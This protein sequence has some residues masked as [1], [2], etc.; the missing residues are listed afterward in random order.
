MEKRHNR[1]AVLET[2]LDDHLRPMVRLAEEFAPGRREAEDW[3]EKAFLRACRNMD[4][5]NGAD[6]K[7]LLYGSLVELIEDGDRR[8]AG[9]S[10]VNTPG[11]LSGE[12]A[13]SPRSV[14]RLRMLM[15][16]VDG[17]EV[18]RVVSDLPHEQRLLTLLYYLAG[19]TQRQ[20]AKLTGL[21]LPQVR[22]RLGDSRR[23]LQEFIWRQ[24]SPEDQH[25]TVES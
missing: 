13:G 10:T 8:I 1:K 16:R 5:N 21:T 23:R 18:Y 25:V 15:S 14:R 19:F 24:A 2:A 6:I 22:R 17:S 3:V 4:R 20:V 9:R 12:F 11:R 7:N